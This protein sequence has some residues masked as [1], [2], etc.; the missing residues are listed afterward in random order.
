MMLMISAKIPFALLRP[1]GSAA[2]LVSCSSGS[3]LREMSANISAKNLTQYIVHLVMGTLEA[4]FYLCGRS[5]QG[6]SH[7]N[8]SFEGI[9]S[10][11]SRLG[12]YGCVLCAGERPGNRHDVDDE[13]MTR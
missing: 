3:S 6:G 11:I 9:W 4:L 7:R 8:S 2:D 5:F 12:G 1:W 10:R 13:K